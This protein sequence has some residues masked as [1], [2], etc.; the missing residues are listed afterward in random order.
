[1]KFAT[2]MLL[3]AVAKSSN[4]NVV[5]D[6]REPDGSGRIIQRVQ[7][8]SDCDN[9]FGSG[10]E[11]SQEACTCFSAIQCRKLCPTGQHLDP[12]Q[13]CQCIPDNEYQTFFNHNLTD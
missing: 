3:Y 9:L 7:S 11:F 5:D 4:L 13:A 8:Q 2:S 10:F 6:Y 12:T 1:M